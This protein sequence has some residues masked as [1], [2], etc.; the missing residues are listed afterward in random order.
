MPT[1]K[2]QKRQQVQ[3]E[4]IRIDK[5]ATGA[6]YAT[7]I[8]VILSAFSWAIPG[9][10]QNK[11]ICAGLLLLTAITFAV[12]AKTSKKESKRLKGVCDALE[13]ELTIKKP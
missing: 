11:L 3:N 13:E 4:K 9:T 8:L 5:K 12:D 6:I 1:V 2:E 7:V 10:T